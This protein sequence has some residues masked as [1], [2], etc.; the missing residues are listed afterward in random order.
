MFR[1]RVFTFKGASKTAKNIITKGSTCVEVFR[2]LSQQLERFCGLEAKNRRH[3]QVKVEHDI[4][5]LIELLHGE[6]VHEK[7]PNRPLWK[8]PIV[9]KNPQKTTSPK[10]VSSVV[11]IISQGYVGWGLGGNI[12]TYI[13]ETAYNPKDGYPVEREEMEEEGGVVIEGE[14]DVSGADATLDVQQGESES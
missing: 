7:Q 14:A 6:R 11:D 9:R 8:A 12:S 4:R 1:Q 2:S 5:T 10:K 13:K 3:Q